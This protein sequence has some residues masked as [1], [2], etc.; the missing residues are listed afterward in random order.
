[1]I[2]DVLPANADSISQKVDHAWKCKKDAC[3][4]H[5]EFVCSAIHII[6]LLVGYA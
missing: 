2:L 5:E 1:M 3:N 4:T 6:D